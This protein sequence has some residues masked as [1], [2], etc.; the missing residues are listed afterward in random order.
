G[1]RRLTEGDVRE[2]DPM[3]SPNA[4]RI[5][6]V[7]DRDGG[8][9]VYVMSSSGAE[10]RR[11]TDGRGLNWSPGWSADGSRITFTSNRDGKTS[12]IYSVALDGS[13]IKAITAGEGAA[14]SPDGRTIA[15]A[16]SGD[17]KNGGFA[18]WLYGASG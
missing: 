11:V 13:G 16:K 14:S 17:G 9:N 15:V 7:S 3:W 18:I 1:L 2:T 12:T 5:A 10:L 4:S 8:L 6:F